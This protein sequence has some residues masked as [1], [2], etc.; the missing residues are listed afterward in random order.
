MAPFGWVVNRIVKELV[1]RPR[2]SHELVRIREIATDPSFPSGH[3]ITAV[4]ILGLLLYFIRI[5]IKQPVLRLILQLACLY[6]IIFS[7]IAHLPR[8]PLV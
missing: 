7:G 6:G 1:M 8:R 4:L 3:V 5:L 2:P